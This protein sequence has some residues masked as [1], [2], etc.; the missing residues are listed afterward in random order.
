MVL[1]VSFFKLA[2]A[3]KL[4]YPLAALAAPVSLSCDSENAKGGAVCPVCPLPA[5]VF[6]D[7]AR[8][9]SVYPSSCECKCK[10]SSQKEYLEL[11]VVVNIHEKG[12]VCERATQILIMNN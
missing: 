12:Q 3:G 6:Q 11:M 7:G 10:I 4:R 1:H 8:I 9:W 5:N 2:G